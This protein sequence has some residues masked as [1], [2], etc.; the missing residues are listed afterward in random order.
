MVYHRLPYEEAVEDGKPVRRRYACRY[1]IV[2][3]G[4]E[5]TGVTK[6]MSRSA[7]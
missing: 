7:A 2:T 3:R 6:R 5:C 4:R 1:R